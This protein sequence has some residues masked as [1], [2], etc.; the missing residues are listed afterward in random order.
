[1][2]IQYILLILAIIILIPIIFYKL[3]F[4]RNPDITIPEGNN[5]ISPANGKITS[6]IKLDDTT[7]DIEIKKTLGKIRTLTNDTTEKG[8]LILI[9][10]DIFNVHYQKAPL[11]GKVISV[12]HTE[13]KFLNAVADAKN[14]KASLENEKTE[15]IIETEIGKIKI[16]QI[17][18]MVARRIVSFVKPE[19]KIIKGQ[20][21]G[22]IKL[23]SQV[24][25]IMPEV[26]LKIK[27]GQKIKVGEIIA[28]Y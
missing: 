20:D 23:G 17:A 22:L 25:L 9:V 4:L 8:Y 13:G 18:G 14:L 2:S 28:E 5:I 21:I 10:M 1:M 6:I 16:V 11:D 26:K 19:Q 15:T 7:E 27:E 3:W 24:A 12:I